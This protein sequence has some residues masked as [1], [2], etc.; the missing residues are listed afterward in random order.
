MNLFVTLPRRSKGKKPSFIW[1][2]ES[3]A[4]FLGFQSEVSFLLII[5]IFLSEKASLK[6]VVFLLT[7]SPNLHYAPKIQVPKWLPNLLVG[8]D[9]TPFILSYKLDP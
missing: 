9:W 2:C 5:Y 6:E 8:V 3:E 7:K 4:V 1:G